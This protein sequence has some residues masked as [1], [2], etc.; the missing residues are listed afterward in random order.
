M[1]TSEISK[2]MAHLGTLSHKKSPRSKEFYREMARRSNKKQGK[3]VDK[4]TGTAQNV[5]DIGS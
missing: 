1:N 3:G 2:V 5:V 4:S